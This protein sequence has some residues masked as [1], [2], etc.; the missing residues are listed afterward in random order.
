[1]QLERDVYVRPMLNTTQK[2]VVNYIND[3]DIAYVEDKTNAESEFARNYI[4]NQVMPVLL[5]KFPNAIESLLSFSQLA[6]LDDQY[7]SSQVP[8][9]SF[10]V[11]GKT[12]S[13]PLNYFI[14]AKPIVARMIFRALA[15]IG[16][17][18]DIE[19]KHI[20]AICELVA[21]SEN[22]KKIEL[23]NKVVASKEYDYLT[24]FNKQKEVVSLNQE[25]KI[26][27]TKI[28]GVGTISVKRTKQRANDGALYVDSKQIPK[29]AVWRFRENGDVFEK[30][31]GGT[32]K[33]KSY[34]IDIKIPQRL[35]TNLPVLASG[36][37]V[38][39]IAGVEISDKVK[40]TE[41]TGFMY[42]IEF[43]REN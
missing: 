27:E 1:M 43:V 3:N 25:F 41:N 32:K 40:I 28:K 18:K 22:G 34:L 14:Y 39:V 23:P 13:I 26:G 36:N 10:I 12:V 2:A 21:S 5:K 30:F 11:N 31:G 37:E 7:I 29:N 16:I 15:S 38:F 8:S 20:D 33:L 35:R 24:L 4:R 42:K 9:D 6:T 19:S 17:T